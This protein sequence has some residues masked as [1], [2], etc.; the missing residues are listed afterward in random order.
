MFNGV[1]KG[2]LRG[3]F[4]VLKGLFVFLG[5]RAV[6]VFFGVMG[7]FGFVI[8]MLFGFLLGVLLTFSCG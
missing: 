2:C 8:L 3:G 6:F 4:G 1:F 7:E 5:G